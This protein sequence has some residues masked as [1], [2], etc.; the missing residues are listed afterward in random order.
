MLNLDLKTVALN[1]Y[2]QSLDAHPEG[3]T[4]KM[5]DMYMS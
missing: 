3:I 2:R 5:E 4:E 1:R